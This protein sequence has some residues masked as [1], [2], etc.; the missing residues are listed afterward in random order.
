LYS[1][2]STILPRVDFIRTSGLHHG[3]RIVISDVYK[4]RRRVRK[5]RFLL[6]LATYR[7]RILT[8]AIWQIPLT[9]QKIEWLQHSR[10]CQCWRSRPPQAP[11]IR[12][13]R[14]WTICVWSDDQLAA[15]D[16][17]KAAFVESRCDAVALGSSISVAAPF[18]RRCLTGSTMAPFSIVPSRSPFVSEHAPDGA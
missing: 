16:L 18:V 13:E 15:D 5:W 8:S 12:Y 7:C 4:V 17:Q 3:A 11:Y 9:M 6:G 14:W 1:N 2:C 10:E